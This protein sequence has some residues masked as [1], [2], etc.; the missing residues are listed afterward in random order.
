MNLRAVKILWIFA[1]FLYLSHFS[2]ILQISDQPPKI[3]DNFLQITSLIFSFTPDFHSA[4]IQ[5]DN[6]FNKT[7]VQKEG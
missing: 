1:V 3:P 6:I 4:K 2:L 5:I 7:N